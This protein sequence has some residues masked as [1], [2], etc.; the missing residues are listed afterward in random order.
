MVKNIVILLIITGFVSCKSSIDYYN[1]PAYSKSGNLQAVI[2]IPSGTSYKYEFQKRDNKF[3]VDTRG[4]KKRKIDFL[5]YPANY[6]YIPSTF[7]D[8]EKGGDGDALDVIVISEAI[9]TGSILEITPIGM[10]KLL[11][12]G[13]LDYK[14]VAVPVAEND[15]IISAENYQ[16]LTTDYSGIKKI[17]EIWFSNYDREEATEILGWGAEK[18]AFLEIKKWQTH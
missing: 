15:K 3:L 11:D 5:P 1:I 6:G 12:D 4:N 17:L 7:S 9:E 14:I 10:L 13:E 2:E 8:P 16:E 18:E